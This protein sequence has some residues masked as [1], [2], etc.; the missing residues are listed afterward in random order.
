MITSSSYL[1]D[2]FHKVTISLPRKP[3]VKDDN[4][5]LL[6][7]SRES[8]QRAMPLVNHVATRWSPDSH[9]CS[10][11]LDGIWLLCLLCFRLLAPNSLIFNLHPGTL[12]IAYFSIP[13]PSII[14]KTTDIH[15]CPQGWLFQ[16]S[17]FFNLHSWP[18][19]GHVISQT[20]LMWHLK[21][22]CPLWSLSYLLKYFTS[23]D[24]FK[25][26]FSVLYLFQVPR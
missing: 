11:N 22:Q 19:H 6:S 14:L 25:S 23:T 7:I 1:K 15:Q 2:R 24:T 5:S 10:M 9:S 13:C 21:L 18:Q 8:G 3:W 12:L 16:Y 4:F 26:T 20:V 17:T